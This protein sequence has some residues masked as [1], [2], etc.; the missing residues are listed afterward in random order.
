M[1]ILWL[2][3]SEP[4]ADKIGH[5]Q[6]ISFEMAIFRVSHGGNMHVAWGLESRSSLI[7]VP[8]ALRD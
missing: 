3:R 6:G 2:E 5:S 4:D 1:V 8:S 7:S